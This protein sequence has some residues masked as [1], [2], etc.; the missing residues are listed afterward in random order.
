MPDSP[1]PFAHMSFA[2]DHNVR[3]HPKLSDEP[4]KPNRLAEVVVDLRLDHQEIEVAVAALLSARVGAEQDHPGIR[5]GGLGK[6]LSGPL[7]QLT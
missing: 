6:G 2:G 4:G 1:P 7:D 3:R 5:A